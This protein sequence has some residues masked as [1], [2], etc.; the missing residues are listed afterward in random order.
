MVIT[1][2]TENETNKAALEV[3]VADDHHLVRRGIRMLLSREADIEVVAEAED[4]QSAV[5]LAEELEPDVVVIDVEM[6]HL[7]G[8]T[9]TRQ[10]QEVAP[11]TKTVVVSLYGGAS[12]VELAMQSGASGYVLKA[13]MFADLLPAVR[14]ALAGRIFFSSSI[15]AS[16]SM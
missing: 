3:V 12:L 7:D 6:P 11:H 16:H 8:I 15:S 14:A 13:D 5:E 10:I 4:G 1:Y 2:D 9:A